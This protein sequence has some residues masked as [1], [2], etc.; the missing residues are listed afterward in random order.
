[1]IK[2]LLLTLIFTQS[3]LLAHPVE[4][5]LNWISDEYKNFRTY[6][7]IDRAYKYIRKGEDDKAKKLLEKVLE[8]DPLN[9]EASA[10]LISLCLKH[11]DKVCIDKYINYLEDKD[12]AY[13]NLYN[14]QEK[15]KNK[16]YKSAIHYSLEALKYNLKP[17]D[18]YFAKLMLIESYIKLGEYDKASKYI[19][20]LYYS[21]T[22]PKHKGYHT[23]LVKLS[24][25]VGRVDLGKK[26]I[27]KYIEAGNTPSDEQ[28]WRWSHISYNL[29]DVKY[30]YK[31][32]S[33][34]SVNTKHLKWQIELLTKLK[35]FN[36]ASKKMELLYSK[37]KTKANKKRLLHLYKLA[38][39]EKKIAKFHLKELKK[40]CNSYSLFY[41]LD[42]YKFDKSKQKEILLKSYPYTCVK[43][44][45]QVQLDFELINL[46]ENK[47]ASKVKFYVDRLTKRDALKVDDYL[48]ISNIYARLGEC[49]NT[50][51]YAQKYLDKYKS[52]LTALKNAGYCYDKKGKKGLAAYY[53]SRAFKEDSSDLELAKNLGYIYSEL[54]RPRKSLRYFEQYL[55]ENKDPNLNLSLA[56]IYF[57]LDLYDK[58]SENIKKY[59]EY[60]FNKSYK[61]YLLKAKLARVNENC[62]DAQ[63][64]YEDALALKSEEYLEYEYIN[65]LKSC[66]KNEK[67][68]LRL[69]KLSK[70]Y[71]NNKE[72]K[73]ALTYAYI[74]V[75]EYEKAIDIAKVSG[76][77][78]EWI[79]NVKSENKY[80]NKNIDIY[81]AETIRL[82]NYTSS[83]NNSPI[84]NASYVGGGV[85]R[86]GYRP[87]LLE[88]YISV[89]AEAIHTNK[90]NF[91]NTLQPSLGVKYQPSLE[92]D[93]SISIQRMFDT[94]KDTIEAT[95]LRAS[96]GFFD[97][98]EYSIDKSQYFYHSLYLDAGRYLEDKSSIFYA[99]YDLG[100]V[101]KIDK[102]YSFLPYLTTGATMNDASN[103][104]ITKFDIGV[105]VSVLHW[106]LDSKYKSYQITSRLKLEA[107]SAYAGNSKDDNTIR[108]QFEIMY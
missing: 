7:R 8:I 26:E 102:T 98:Y 59:E 67:A 101:Y 99:N 82:D 38:G 77:D 23:H 13:F 28:L 60:N 37:Q 78:D 61:Y 29:K 62:E 105:G 69:E 86:V 3:L 47:D 55:K 2:I 85:L 64:Y 21:K 54:K 9:K 49:S 71:S 12:L 75:K 48:K 53:L 33:S 1:M 30:A 34:L 39:E 92:Y 79:Y 81:F 103:I 14:A 43:K 35:S 20:K 42:Y 89:F 32:A 22:I 106:S 40:G 100:R 90:G 36:L 83:E 11:N 108:L 4:N 50:I 46:L 57:D 51:K 15:I 88:N 58:S 10:P 41:L 97:G 84:Y 27:A 24:I 80:Q 25:E 87:D 72:Y 45:K 52:N 18:K 91:N 76:F 63:G 96:A 66:D 95:F 19:D 94:S 107:R 93:I 65:Y 70:K 56:L 16:N 44:D 104:S 31:L 5:A 6:P 68:L 73:K 74:D 17:E